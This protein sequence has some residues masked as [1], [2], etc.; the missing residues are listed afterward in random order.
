MRHDTITVA[1]ADGT[2]LSVERWLPDGEATAIVQVVH[3]MAE[4]AARYA[5]L[6]EALTGRGWAVYADDHR[7]HGK[8]GGDLAAAGSFAPTDGWN[9]VVRDQHTLSDAYRA[10]HPSLP[11]VLLG[12][13]L[14]SIIARDYALRWGADLAG[15]VLTGTPGSAGALG[16]VGR[17][18]AAREAARHGATAASP[19][20]DQLSFGG[21]NKAFRPNRTDFDWLSRDAAEVD[22]YVADPWCGFVCSAGFFVDMLDGLRRVTDPRL[23]AGLPA[24]LPIL[25]QCGGADPVSRQ[26]EAAHELAR[27]FGRAGVSDVTAVVYEGARHELFNETNRDEITALTTGW[28]TR[29]LA[30]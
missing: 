9:V 16:A 5:R 21:F 29:R 17:A 3:G 19:R 14:G 2:P 24:S 8:T 12:H 1:A 25:V 4:H 10:A 23:L 11:L 28:I 27:A 6:A 15:L 13:S 30:G 22:A 20:L 18:L 26:G 7:G